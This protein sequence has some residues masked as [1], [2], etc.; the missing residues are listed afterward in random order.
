M[1]LKRTRKIEEEFEVVFPFYRKVNK[2]GFFEIF[3]ITENKILSISKIDIDKSLM[4]IKISDLKQ[5]GFI[6]KLFFEYEEITEQEFIKYKNEFDLMY[7]K[8]F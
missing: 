5:D 6:E 4:D 8:M 2:Y 7:N 1:K 3:K